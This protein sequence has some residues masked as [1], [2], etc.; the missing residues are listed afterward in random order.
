MGHDVGG[1]VIGALLCHPGMIGHLVDVRGTRLAIK[2]AAPGELQNQ[3]FCA[4]W[5]TH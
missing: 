4:Q 1:R 2:N 5:P 3:T